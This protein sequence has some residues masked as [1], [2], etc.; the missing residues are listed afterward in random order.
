MLTLPQDVTFSS[1][2]DADDMAELDPEASGFTTSFS[3][4]GAAEGKAVDPVADV[5]DVKRFASAEIAKRSAE[6]PGRVAGLMGVARESE[7]GTVRG[8]EEYMA[9]NG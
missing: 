5:Q 8:W 6:R 1:S 4:L 2:A 9:E 3:R 7:A